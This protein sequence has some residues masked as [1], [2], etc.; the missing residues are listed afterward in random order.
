[1]A[2]DEVRAGVAKSLIALT[3]AVPRRLRR[4]RQ[5]TPPE[6]ARAILRDLLASTQF[7]GDAVVF[8]P[9]WRGRP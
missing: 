1:M 2:G 7:T 3:A 9:G 6:A 8:C 4:A 5:F